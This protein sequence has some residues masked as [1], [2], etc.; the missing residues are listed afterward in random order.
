M[1]AEPVADEEGFA[2]VMVPITDLPRIRGH[3]EELQRRK[4]AR[5]GLCQSCNGAG[6]IEGTVCLDCLGQGVLLFREEYDWLLTVANR[7]DDAILDRQV[8]D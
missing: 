5:E 2:K 1:I 3:V 6:A 4:D 8:F 7:A